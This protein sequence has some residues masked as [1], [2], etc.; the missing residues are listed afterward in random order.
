M[1]TYALAK[2]ID[3]SPT[4]VRQFESAELKGSI[5]LSTLS[6]VANALNCRLLYV[7]VPDEP[8]EDMVQAQAERKAAARLSISDPEKLENEAQELSELLRLQAFEDLTREL[9]DRPG[10]WS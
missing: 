1:S 2:R 5:R 3:L 6:R 8:L 10:L 4:R 9:V 7:F